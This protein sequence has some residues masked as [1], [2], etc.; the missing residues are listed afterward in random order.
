MGKPSNLLVHG[1][2]HA[3]SFGVQRYKWLPYAVARGTGRR[4][5]G[6][7]LSVSKGRG[8][9]PKQEENW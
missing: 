8:M 6:A 3:R 7:W 5:R 4:R 9:S 1:A 2:L